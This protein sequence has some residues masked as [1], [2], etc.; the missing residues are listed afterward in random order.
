MKQFKLNEIT[1]LSMKEKR[2]RK[3][4]F[5][6]NR[7]VIIGGNDTGKSCLLKSIYYTFGADAHKMHP[8]WLDAEPISVVNF[9]LDSEEYY[10]FRMGKNY[11]LFDSGQDKI[12]LY[13]KVS[14]LGEKLAELFSF[15]I[16]L[17]NKEG[18]A[19]TPPPAYQFL[20][21][22]MDQDIS[23]L[24]NWEGFTKLYLPKARLDIINYHTGIRPNKYYITKNELGIVS[25]G[26]Q[27]IDK[28]IKLIRTLLINLKEKLSKAEFT[29]DLVTFEAELKELLVQCQLLKQ[30][31]DKYKLK[32][33]NLYNTKINLEA[34]LLIVKKAL[35][36]TKKDY[37]Y[38][39]DTLGEVVPCP[40]CGAEYENSFAERFG[41]AQDE[42][43]CYDLIVELDEELKTVLA[44]IKKINEEFLSNERLLAQIENQ[45]E[46]KQGEI[47]LKDVIESEGKKEVQK[48][49]EQEIAAYDKELGE[50]ILL[51]DSLESDLKSIEDKVRTELIRNKYRGYMK[52]F[53]G[54][55]NLAAVKEATYKN[56]DTHLSE[57]G[58]KTPR[59]LM[60]YYYSILHVMNEY[61]SSTFFPII[62]DS[63]NQQ[64]QDSKNLPAMLN[65][66]IKEQVP[67][68]QLVLSIEEDH[69]IDYQAEIVRLTDDRSLLNN[70]AYDEH[71]EDIKPLLNE[72]LGFRL[73]Y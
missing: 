21:F 20:P 10:M 34:Q 13:N 28:E 40:S 35:E 72:V 62:V 39:T 19:V 37:H 9:S 3:V 5:H 1:L 36:E 56:I 58:S 66:I 30:E 27:T 33:T 71:F 14:E 23:W 47:K 69:G 41:I 12:G 70:L 4:K 73:F 25:D 59:E 6:P 64:G 54:Q 65:F 24:K 45:L 31:Q 15:E 26:I 63:P 29:M 50:K 67:G 42:Q 55:L 8:D 18:I 48:L 11:A 49:F 22:Y 38:A 44:M 61:S 43:R 2:S 16:K 17:P 53:L 57:G 7:T 52:R 60:A 51:R 68:S 32:L 46:Q